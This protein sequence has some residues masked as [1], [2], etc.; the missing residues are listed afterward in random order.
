MSIIIGGYLYVM[1]A[2]KTILYTK[3]YKRYPPRTN[4][5]LIFY[6]IGLTPKDFKIKL[7]K[8]NRHIQP[9]I[10]LFRLR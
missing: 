6:F 1:I 10:K 9:L 7:W 5:N 2:A 3:E 8:I 4:I